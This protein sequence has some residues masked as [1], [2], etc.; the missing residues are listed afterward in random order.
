MTD[1]AAVRQAYDELGEQYAAARSQ[2]R[3]VPALQAFT[4][5]LSLESGA[6]RVIDA[7]CG[8]GVLLDQLPGTPVGI[9]VS[10]SQLQVARETVPEAELLQGDLTQLPVAAD[11]AAGV[12]ATWSLIHV[13]HTKAAIDEFTRVLEPGGCVLLMEGT[14]GWDGSNDD[15]LASGVEMSWSMAGSV[16]LR[17][18]LRANGFSI[19]DA[20]RITERL[21]DNND[22]DD[23]GDDV[24]SAGDD[25]DSAGDDVDSAGDDVDSAGE[26]GDNAAE[27]SDEPAEELIRI[28]PEA[29]PPDGENTHP[30][31]LYLAR[32][33]D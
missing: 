23:S 19:T 6:T 3:I 2:P 24:D 17:R 8:P 11:T 30:W 5:Q 12:I 7:G 9:D 21:N 32:L 13:P 25:V 16:E 31:T 33:D 15:W 29:N 1:P 18:L 22:T 28:D 26:T 10:G 4:E 20:W 27:S 14:L